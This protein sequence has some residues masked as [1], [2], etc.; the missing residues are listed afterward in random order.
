MVG[1]GLTHF[2]FFGLRSGCAWYQGFNDWRLP[3]TVQP[4]P[5]CSVQLSFSGF[6]QGLGANCTASE[7]GHLFNV[8]NISVGSP[9]PFI[10]LQDGYWSG[11]G[12]APAPDFAWMFV[13]GG[14]GVGEQGIGTV[15]GVSARV[16]AVRDGDVVASVPEPASMFLLGSGATALAF[17]R[18]K[19]RKKK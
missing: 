2:K 6:P 15:F 13:F 11:T 12:V 18:R 8:D 16:W 5:T 10:N 19:R 1:P 3:I 4:D 14:I 9:G 17:L 7:M